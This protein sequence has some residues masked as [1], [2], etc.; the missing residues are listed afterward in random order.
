MTKE[1]LE[2][3]RRIIEIEDKIKMIDDDL[4]NKGFMIYRKIRNIAV[5]IGYTVSEDVLRKVLEE[6]KQRLQNTIKYLMK[7]D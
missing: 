3:A 2:V 1:D 5:P 7:G 4:Q 6:E